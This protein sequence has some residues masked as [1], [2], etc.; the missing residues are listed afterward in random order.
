MNY[1]QLFLLWRT[2]HGNQ[3]QK[4]AVL[5]QKLMEFYGFVNSDRISGYADIEKRMYSVCLQFHQLWKRSNYMEARALERNSTFLDKPFPIPSS[6]FIEPTLF[7]QPTTSFIKKGRRRLSFSRSTD[8][9]KRRKTA[10]LRFNHSADEL[11][12]A[13]S[14]KLREEG[15]IDQASVV[16]LATQTTPRRASKMLNSMK[17]QTCVVQYT[18]D[19]ALAFLLDSD[20]TKAQYNR[21]RL[22]AKQRNV[23]LYPSYKR[24]LEAKKKCYPDK[25]AV[26]ISETDMKITLQA[27]LDHT[28]E[29]IIYSLADSLEKFSNDELNN[30][31]LFVKYGCDGSSGYSE[32]NQ[33]YSNDT[34][35]TKSDSHIFVTSIVPIKATT[36]NKILF[37]NPKPSSVR[38]CRPLH[39]QSKKETT[40]LILAEKADIVDQ[41]KALQPTKVECHGRLVIVKFELVMTMVDVKVVNTLT[42][43][44]S[45]QRCYIC[46]AT[47]KFMN[48]IDEV[49]KREIRIET[50]EYGLSP[51]HAY[52]RF[53][54]YFLHISYRIDIQKW[55]ARSPTEKESVARNKTR[56]QK[57]FRNELGLKVDE[58]RAGG[59]GNSNCGNSSRCFFKNW[60]ISAEITGIKPELL[61]R[62]KTIL[63]AINSG[64]NHC[65]YMFLIIR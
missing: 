31:V 34:D 53:F 13:S 39:I 18:P 19:E 56:L 21:M 63:E 64:S 44:S 58:P 17:N 45:A 5:L 27:L 59:D 22:G 36:E 60:S 14:M 20:L 33:R 48:N 65:C 46:G 8:S 43:T 1:R 32:F 40:A 38:F 28:A 35:G 26:T 50:A 30:V 15:K 9:V 7:I 24:V 37:Q 57:S 2:S 4:S 6:K 23:D 47:P 11:A 16:Q 62:C 52:I 51:L 25:S 10:K 41:V 49:I 54:E 12:F 3:K 55:Q 29:R 42:S 61:Y